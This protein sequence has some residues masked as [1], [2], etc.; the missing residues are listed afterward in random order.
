MFEF[1]TKKKLVEIDDWETLHSFKGTWQINSRYG[2]G[3][4]TY[5]ECTFSVRYSESRD[6]FQALIGG[7][8]PKDHKM[9]KVATKI[10]KLYENAIKEDKDL[11]EVKKEID[12]QLSELNKS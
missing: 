1:L 12:G 4:P 3:S 7:H 6:D 8:N 10:I 2:G 9:F 11:I 5:K